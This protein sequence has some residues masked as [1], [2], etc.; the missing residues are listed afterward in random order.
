MGV[1]GSLWLLLFVDVMT[2]P[3]PNFKTGVT[4]LDYNTL[5]KRQQFIWIIVELSNEHRNIQRY[6]KEY[7]M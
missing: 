4:N 2:S 6:H 3:H 7:Q 1:L 5:Y